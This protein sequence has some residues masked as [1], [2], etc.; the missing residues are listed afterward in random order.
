MGIGLDC[1]G[2]G[3]RIRLQV[4]LVL[5]RR[6]H[7]SAAFPCIPSPVDLELQAHSAWGGGVPFA[8]R[9]SICAPSTPLSTPDAQPEGKLAAGTSIVAAEGIMSAAV[10]ESD[11]AP[12]KDGPSD[13]DGPL[14]YAPKK[15]RQAE[16]DPNPGALVKSDAAP[17]TVPEA[18][19]PPWKRSKQRDALAGDAALAARRNRLALAPVRLPAPPPPSST[20]P[21]YVWTG[22]LAGVAVV[23]AVG[24][25]GYQ[26][27]SAPPA[28]SPQLTVR[29][30]QSS[31]QKLASERSEPAAYLDSRGRDSKAAAERPA[32]GGLS[33]TTTIDAAAT[34]NAAPVVYPPPPAEPAFAPPAAANAIVQTPVEPMSPDAASPRAAPELSVG[35]AR[36]LQA[37][38]AARLTVSAADAGANATVV[39]G[40]LEPGS[41][42]SAGRQEGPNAWRLAVEELAGMAITPPPG[43]VGTMALTLEL[44]LADSTVADRKAVQLEWSAKSALAPVKP[45]PR[46]HDAAEIALMMKNGADMMTNRDVAGARLLYMRAAEAG[47]ALAAF[48]LAETYDPLV[49]R[50][51]NA[52]G[53]IAPDVALARGWYERARDLGSATAP[54]RLERLARLA[55]QSPE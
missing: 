3:D 23:A 14:S 8:P 1:K 46:Q 54:E 51:L 53:G 25:V 13:K 32:A 44:Q 52:R 37:D 47:D 16:A 6:Q 28:T 5:R 21:R 41:A 31:Q 17:S 27:G 35:V 18:L 36:P 11:E 40:G 22:R 2:D 38:E 29:P 50:K 45:Q 55:E 26:L 12:L 20:G 48:A 33:T 24:V 7:S 30:G 34:T 39:V 42:L 10:R 4:G 49:L 19:E 15:L 9:V 43:F